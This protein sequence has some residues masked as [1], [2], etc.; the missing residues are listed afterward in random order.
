MR[1]VD[2]VPGKKYPTILRIHGGPVGQF[3]CSLEEEWQWFAGNG[4]VVVAANPRGS[5]GRGEE[6]QK[7]IYADW[8]NRDAEDVSI[9]DRL[10]SAT[11]DELF[12]FI[13]NELG[14]G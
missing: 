5:S 13:D 2:Y 10:E 7:A 8:G 3:E 6:F 11:S 1:P 14:E 4:Y 9:T 12:D